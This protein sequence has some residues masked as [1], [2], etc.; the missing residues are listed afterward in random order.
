MRREN[1][2][3]D[4]ELA[5]SVPVNDHDATMN[6][7]AIRSVCARARPEL[8]RSSYALRNYFSTSQWLATDD[9]TPNDPNPAPTRRQR[10]QAATSEITSLVRNNGPSTPR[11]WPRQASGPESGQAKVLDVRSLPRGGFRGRGGFQGRGR[12]GAATAGRE[13]TFTQRGFSPAE[14]DRPSRMDR[15]GFAS[16]GLRGRGRGRGGLHGGEWG[17]NLRDKNADTDAEKDFQM[18]GNRAFNRNARKPK[19]PFEVMDPAEEA[20]DNDMRFGTRTQYTPSLTL[21]DLAPFMPADAS[22]SQGRAATVLQNLSALGT[23]DPVGVPQDLQ[24]SCYAEDLEN[25]GVRFFA[26]AKARDA[27]EAYLQKKRRDEAAKKA[28][29]EGVT[30]EESTE[31][32][33]QDADEAI[34]RVIFDKAVAGQYEKPEFAADPVGVSRSWHLRAE[35]YTQKDIENFEKKLKSL[36]GAGAAAGGKSGKANNATA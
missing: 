19:D 2:S 4:G 32:I 25:A 14:G 24:G 33:I 35:T 18:D 26:D 28:R 20:F 29:E 9:T 31:R 1:W 16:R 36:M 3:A 11:Q 17:D 30:M 7:Q 8:E 12:G 34:R 22:T 5:S 23:A 27:A 6:R 13:N 21:E 15:D 10:T